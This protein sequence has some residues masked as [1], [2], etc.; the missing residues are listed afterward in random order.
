MNAVKTVQWI[1]KERL[2][3]LLTVD[4]SIGKLKILQLVLKE[5]QECKVAIPLSAEHILFPPDLFGLSTKQIL[6][7]G[8]LLDLLCWYLK[9]WYTYMCLYG[10]NWP[11]ICVIASWRVFVI[12]TLQTWRAS[13]LCKRVY[14][15]LRPEGNEWPSF[16]SPFITYFLS[17]SLE[18]WAFSWKTNVSINISP[19]SLCSAGWSICP[20][21]LVN[22]PKILAGAA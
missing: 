15:H 8:L 16:K 20:S 2:L 11:D 19:S 21:A 10:Q 13:A 6:I 5:N 14:Q 17:P 18:S 1:Q 4:L 3:D 9:S 22:H 12:W 7:K